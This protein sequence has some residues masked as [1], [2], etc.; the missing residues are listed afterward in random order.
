LFQASCRPHLQIHFREPLL[1]NQP[2]PERG[3]DVLDHHDRFFAGGGEGLSVLIH[4]H[5]VA[6]HTL[7]RRLAVAVLQERSQ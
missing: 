7:L 6:R 1:V 2:P 3:A 4:M 5:L